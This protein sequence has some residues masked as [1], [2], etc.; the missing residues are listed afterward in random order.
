MVNDEV[1]DETGLGVFS[2]GTVQSPTVQSCDACCD[3]D[4]DVAAQADRDVA[5]TESHTQLCIPEFSSCSDSLFSMRSD[6]S[7]GVTCPSWMLWRETPCSSFSSNDAHNSSVSARES[8]KLECPTWVSHPGACLNAQL[9]VD[10][11]VHQTISHAVHNSSYASCDTWKRQQVAFSRSR[12]EGHVDLPRLQSTCSSH[13]QFSIPTT[14]CDNVHAQ[15]RTTL[16]AVDPH[17]VS[18]SGGGDNSDPSWLQCS[19]LR[20]ARKVSFAENMDL[21]LFFA[22][23]HIEC[24][25]ERKYGAKLCRHFWHLYGQITNWS[26]MVRILY[27]HRRMMDNVHALHQEVTAQARTGDGEALGHVHPNLRPDTVASRSDA[28]WWNDLYSLMHEEEGGR[29]KFVATWFVSPGRFPLCIQYKR[30]KIEDSDDFR[31]F[32]RRALFAWHALLDDQQVEFHLVEGNPPRSTSILAHV[33][34]VQGKL[35][36]SNFVLFHG[37]SMP[38]SRRTRA[39]LFEQDMTV[40]EFFTQ[41]QFPEACQQQRARCYVHCQTRLDV[42]DLEDEQ[43]CDLPIAAYVEGDLRLVQ[44]DEEAIDSEDA[45]TGTTD[46]TGFPDSEGTDAENLASFLQDEITLHNSFSGEQD[47]WGTDHSEQIAP[48]DLPQQYV[49]QTLFRGRVEDNSDLHW[50]QGYDFVNISSTP[51]LGPCDDVHM[52]NHKASFSPAFPDDLAVPTWYR[53]AASKGL[54]GEGSA[55]VE[56]DR[57]DDR[58]AADDGNISEFEPLI[59]G[60]GSSGVNIVNSKDFRILSDV[61]VA[62]KCEHDAV[63]HL[64]TDL[65][66]T[67]IE[68]ENVQAW[69]WGLADSCQHQTSCSHQSASICDAA[70]HRA[71]LCFSDDFQDEIFTDHVSNQCESVVDSKEADAVI[72][73]PYSSVKAETLDPFDSHDG[74]Y[75]WCQ[76]VDEK[77]LLRVCGED[78]VD[79]F[80]SQGD[81]Q[82]VAPSQAFRPGTHAHNACPHGRD[83]RSWSFS[84]SSGSVARADAKAILR[85]CREGNLDLSES[86]GASLQKSVDLSFCEQEAGSQPA[87]QPNRYISQKRVTIKGDDPRHA[88]SHRKRNVSFASHIQIHCFHDSATYSATVHQNRFQACARSLWH[89]DGQVSDPHQW[90]RVCGYFDETPR[91]QA[92]HASGPAQKESLEKV[93]DA[94]PTNEHDKQMDDPL[95]LKILLQEQA[96]PIFADTWFLDKGRFPVCVRPRKLRLLPHMRFTA[97]LKRACKMLWQDLDNQED[98]ELQ[99]VHGATRLPSIMF[100]ILVVQG[101]TQGWD[102]SIITSQ[103][104]PPLYQCRAVASPKGIRVLDFFEYA[105][106]GEVCHQRARTC[107]VKFK[108]NQNDVLLTTHMAFQPPVNPFIEGGIRSVSDDTESNSHDDADAT[109]DQS[110]VSQV[111]TATGESDEED[112]SS[113]M[114]GHPT[115]MQVTDEDAYPWIQQPWDNPPIEE[116]EIDIDFADTHEAHVEEYINMVLDAAPD[117]DQQWTAITFGVEIVDIGRRDVEFSPWDLNNLLGK[118]HEAWADYAARARLTV[119]YVFPQPSDIGGERS[120]VLIVNVE[121]PETLEEDTRYILVTERG[122]PG[123]VFRSQPYAARVTTEINARALLA[124]LNLHRQ[125]F[126]FTVRPCDV[127]MAFTSMTEDR[128]YNIEH[129]ANCNVWFGDV[130]REIQT[131]QTQVEE[132]D[133]FLLQVN[134]MRDYQGARD[135]VICRVHGVSPQN[136]PLGSRD[137][138]TTFDQLQNND[139]IQQIRQIWPFTPDQAVIVFVASA[140]E[141]GSD[142]RVAI[143]HFIVAYGN[144]EG[145]PVLVGQQIVAVEAPNAMNNDVLERWAIVL[146]EVLISEEVVRS[147]QRP[148][149]WFD[150][151][152]R[153]NVRPHL[154]VNGVRLDDTGRQWA[155]GDYLQAR[156]LVWQPQHILH[157]MAGERDEESSVQVEHTSFIQLQ[158]PVLHPVGKNEHSLADTTRPSEPVTERIPGSCQQSI[159]DQGTMGNSLVSSLQSVLGQLFIDNWQGLNVDFAAVPSTHPFAQ[160]ACSVTPTAQHG[161]V[162]HIFSDGS[163]QRHTAA[164]SFVVLCEANVTSS[165]QFF[166]IGYAAG[167]VC[168]DLGEYQVSALDAE[169]T[170]LIAA[171]EYLLSK[172]QCRQIEVFLHFDATTAGFGACGQQRTA[173][174]QDGSS[175]RQQAARVMVSL[176][177]QCTKQVHGLH[178]KSHVGQPWNECADSIA[179]HVCKGWHPPKAA[180]LR[181]K[182]LLGHPL[183]DWAWIEA[184]P[185]IELPGLN[186]ILQNHFKRSQTYVPEAVL[187]HAHDDGRRSNSQWQDDDQNAIRARHLT[188]ATANVGTLDYSGA[189]GCVSLKANELL[190]QFQEAELHIIGIQE[191][192][193]KQSAFRLQG[194]FARYIS[195]GSG[196]QA[197]VELW[198]QW[199]KI[200]QIFG[201]DFHPEKDAAVWF[202]SERILATRI[203][204]GKLALELVVAYAPQRGKSSQE[205]QLW[206]ETFTEVVNKRDKQAL[207]FVMGDMNCSIGSV[208]GLANGSHCYDIEDDP[209]TFWRELCEKCDLLIPSTFEDFHQ[210][211]SHTYVGPRG[212]QSRLDFIAM[213]Q[214][215]H[216]GIS[217]SYTNEAI[218]LLNGD[219]DHIMLC[220]DMTLQVGSSRQ[221][222]RMQ[223]R[224]LYDRREARAQAKLSKI[225]LLHDLPVIEWTTDVNDHWSILREHLQCK[226]K[227]LYPCPKRQQRQL[228]FTPTAWQTLCD[229]KDVRQQFR[230]LQR[231]QKHTLLKAVWHAWS[232][233]TKQTTFSGYWRLQRV[234]LW[235]QEAVLY[236]ARMRLDQ[237]FRTQK[238]QAWKQWIQ[239]QLDDKIQQAGRA[240]SNEL[241]A[242]LQ[243]KQMIAKASGRLVKALPGFVDE[244][245]NLQRNRDEVAVAWQEQFS[246]IEHAEPV[247]L[248]AL[249]QRSQPHHW[250]ERDETELLHI[251][252][253][254]ELE[255]AIRNLNEQKAAGVDGLGPELFQSNPALTARRLFPLVLKA[256]IRGQAVV[257]FCGGWLLPL[258]KKKGHQRHMSGYRG[259][260]LEPTISRA[261]SRAWRPQLLKGILAAA[262]PM[263]WG[264]RSG[265][266]IES[267]HLHVQLW[268]SAARWEKQAQATIFVDIRAAF[269]SVI[270]HIVAGTACGMTALHTVFARLKLPNEMWEAFMAHMENNNLILQATGSKLVAQSVAATLGHTWFCIPD[271]NNIFSP[272]TGSRPGD[273]NADLLFSFVLSKVLGHI[274]ERASERGIPL[275]RQSAHGEISDMVTWVDDLAISVTSTPGTLVNK[276]VEVMQIIQDSML[277]HGLALSFGAGKTAVLMAYHGKGAVQARQQM[278]EKY[279]DGIP[280]LSEFAPGVKIPVVSHY[281]HLGGHITRSGSRL[282]ELRIRTGAALAKLKPLRKIL[283]NETLDQTKRSQLIKSMGLSVFSLHAGKSSWLQ[284]VFQALKWARTQVGTETI[285]E[286]LFQLHDF[287]MWECFHSA[288][289]ELKKTFKQ[290]ERAHLCKI[291]TLCTLQQHA[292]SQDDLLRDMGWTMENDMNEDTMD[293]TGSFTCDDCGAVF[294]QA[295]TLAVHQQRAHGQRVALRRFIVDAACRACGKWYHSRPRALR[296]V[297][298]TSSKCWVWHMRRYYPLS[299]E[300]TSALDEHDRKIGVAVHQKGLKSQQHDQIWRFCTDAELVDR[301][302]VKECNEEALDPFEDPSE[303]ELQEWA[304]LGMLP[305]GQGGRE[306][307]V[308]KQT[309]LQMHHVGLETAKVEKQLLENVKKW[310]PNYDYVPPP[311]ADGRKFFLIFFAGHRRIGDL[312][313]WFSWLSADVIPIPIDLAIDTEQGNIFHDHL[314]KRLIVARKVIGG[315]GGPPCETFSLARWIQIADAVFPRPLRTTEQPWGCDE[316]TL[317]EVRQTLVGNILMFRAL[318][319]LLLIYAFGGS[320]TLEHPAGCG[321]KDHRWSIWESAFVQQLMLA[322]DIRRWTILQGPLGQPFAKP[323]NILAARLERLGAAMYEGYNKHWKPTV[324]LGGREKGVWKTAQAKA[325]PTEMNRILAAQHLAFADT[326]TAEGATDEP[327]GLEMALAMLTS[328]DPYL[329][330]A[331]GVEGAM[332]SIE[333][334]LSHV[335][336]KP[337][338]S[339]SIVALVPS[340]YPRN[341]PELRARDPE[342][343]I[344]PELMEEL[345]QCGAAA[346]QSAF[347]ASG[348][349]VFFA[350]DQ[351]AALLRKR[352]MIGGEAPSLRP[353]QEG[354]NESGDPYQRTGPTK[355]GTWD[356]GLDGPAEKP[357][358]RRRRRRTGAMVLPFA[359][360][361]DET[362]QRPLPNSTAPPLAPLCEPSLRGKAKATPGSWSTGISTPSSI[363]EDQS[364][365]SSSAESSSE[366][367]SS[368]VSDDEMQKIAAQLHF[369]VRRQMLFKA[370]SRGKAERACDLRAKRE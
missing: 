82:T 326:R 206:W 184:N 248:D 306:V 183:R 114:S 75:L 187:L 172:S 332:G 239:R 202:S 328:Y 227:S 7:G 34:I 3:S 135:T 263:Q 231:C 203:Q 220:L 195:A 300:E 179:H 95:L 104:L 204:L 71:T 343:H 254:Y 103:M 87:P 246:T 364:S 102:R 57:Y 83:L 74:G 292:K 43:V 107:F 86:H 199:R 77:A 148:P 351:V 94:G 40:R 281:K 198:I 368:G 108:V 160:A 49:D 59:F 238:R 73:P 291:R 331:K 321:G 133:A 188:F 307:T 29:A 92:L 311:M 301:L 90:Q 181:S 350:V 116:E 173:K 54:L 141:D 266:S 305:P 14:N 130:P 290:V 128:P 338:G 131:A 80:D 342:R 261:I 127:R 39:V 93:F 298:L 6:D 189:D 317:R 286:E 295:A 355:S 162:F 349:A 175:V 30:V 18:K 88:Q 277:E 362:T 276:V 213:P 156:F 366:S 81:S 294:P 280:I 325:Y 155:A 61:G 161:N 144:P 336:Q 296:H 243:P 140:T 218:D 121:S 352:L 232:A 20:K 236:E 348:P 240:K 251:P 230:H 255:E 2:H 176:L 268:R 177:Q 324:W 340:D 272:M 91:E 62:D 164:W 260:L 279:K 361:E 23:Q 275:L 84:E 297:Q 337:K 76:D 138:Y 289:H 314:W 4:S 369:N 109:D 217:R 200:G 282:P 194:E 85:D 222:K 293:T 287:Q 323:T 158:R 45:S 153:L 106:F 32:K 256:A 157:I 10:C 21:H 115:L 216:Q 318:F 262:R 118:I 55:C 327:A 313:S 9:P 149:F 124:Q 101:E 271:G 341:R 44:E 367:S 270:K 288:A 52:S 38:S 123:T 159:R 357:N 264:G 356:L 17:E 309:D 15:N 363:S 24:S 165:R 319:L 224:N 42:Q 154:R 191:S 72:H 250:K 25:I 221:M 241:F 303:E 235:Q 132:V 249:M 358:R 244:H 122:V 192:R 89:L 208:T 35:P 310:L 242:I 51:T 111:T 48:N 226:A 273:P 247:A 105:Q 150:P 265:L 147:L 223:K 110:T 117:P 152:R 27:G 322:G 252:T 142:Q 237:K 66:N 211:P 370:P 334:D 207:L 146:D 119:Y 33:I 70:K 41:A 267:L 1:I 96:L 360:K 67:L 50:P 168:D 113:L 139:W 245:G 180:N 178:T 174:Y 335:L 31:S 210:G 63:E 143:Y 16:P 320:F 182:D 345:R 233:Q 60:V 225:N 112:D 316:R 22:E 201:V 46:T 219:K 354:T 228:Y 163:H 11:D 79:L 346:L 12:G 285:P 284:G 170:G 65:Q 5:M 330:T 347:A 193:A 257:E 359:E 53:F 197:G 253:V 185:S 353:P 64:Y 151:A 125:C 365:S 258:W 100:H 302:S 129:G 229:R 186:F 205:L 47:P 68:L 134:A 304:K 315:H 212:Q 97:Q 56:T 274:L 19:P 69:T 196:G 329:E 333:V 37:V 308:R 145:A 344:D 215:C 137:V 167:L 58:F 98:I 99:I 28:C 36:Q 214:E 278:E 126:P 209:G 190:H 78:N 299:L 26:E 269:Y 136:Q 120:L 312:A 339:V 234:I 8:L 171:T 166:R 283:T 13:L 259:I 169:A